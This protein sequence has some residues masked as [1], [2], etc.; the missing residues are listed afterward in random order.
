M[1]LKGRD[2]LK[3]QAL[4]GIHPYQQFLSDGVTQSKMWGQKYRRF[5][6]E[7]KVFVLPEDHAYC[8]AFD[9]ANVYSVVLVADGENIVFASHTTIQQEVNMA[10]TD[11]LIA[12]FTVDSFKDVKDL[13][14]IP[15]L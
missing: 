12:S 4:A 14:S 10:K 6:Y 9:N 5:G 15:S 11:A 1:E 7:A 2:S 13:S 3:V 8:T